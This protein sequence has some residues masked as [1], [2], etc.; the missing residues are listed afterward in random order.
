MKTSLASFQSKIKHLNLDKKVL[1]S[2]KARKE[3]EKERYKSYCDVGA[4]SL[5]SMDYI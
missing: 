4:L 5:T 1:K 3:N 2:V